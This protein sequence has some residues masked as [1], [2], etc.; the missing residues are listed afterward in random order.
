MQISYP[1]LSSSWEVTAKSWKARVLCPAG[2]GVGLEFAS[3][4]YLRCRSA[5]RDLLY[6]YTAWHK[7][8]NKT[9]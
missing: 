6:G 7:Q 1:A 2:Q 9:M 8:C 3:I 5:G 4:A